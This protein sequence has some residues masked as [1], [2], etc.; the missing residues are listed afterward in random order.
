M[1][2]DFREI[3][4]DLF[5]VELLLSVDAILIDVRTATELQEEAAIEG[6]IN[7]DYL[8]DDFEYEIQKFNKDLPILIYC[9][10]GVR[11][12]KASLQFAKMG[13]MNVMNLEGGKKALDKILTEE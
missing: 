6:S 1:M 10:N 2:N 12:R 8:A 5:I 4:A 13:F 7:I 11:G 9:N 3:S